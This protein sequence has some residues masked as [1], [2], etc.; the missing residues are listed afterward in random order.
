[1]GIK[2]D[3]LF[4]LVKERG[5]TEYWLRQNGISPSILN[6]LKH[7]AGGLDAR[8]IEKLCRLLQCQPSD[9]ME[10]VEDEKTID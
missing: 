1:M 2:Y 4:S 8:T 6:K 7:K 10:Y 3:K 9:I 5:K